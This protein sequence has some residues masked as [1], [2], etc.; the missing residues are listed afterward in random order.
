MYVIAYLHVV[1][2]LKTEFIKKMSGME[3]FKI[4]GAQQTKL[5]DNYSDN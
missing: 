5:D 3:N 4:I 2:V 1:R